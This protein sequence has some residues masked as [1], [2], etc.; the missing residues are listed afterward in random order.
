MLT[1]ASPGCVYF[2]QESKAREL[3]RQF[4]AEYPDRDIKVYGGDC[5]AEIPKALHDLREL[6]WAP[7]FAFIDPDGMEFEW[8]TLEALADHK[9]GY[10]PMSSPKPEYKVELWLLFPTQG[11][12]RTLALTQRSSP[13]G[14]SARH[15]ALWHRRLALSTISA[16]KAS[17]T[18][19]R[20]G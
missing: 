17:S 6:R 5:N 15:G 4:E 7:T 3:E 16:S 13:G 9:R 10:R 1:L 11:L 14:R 8:R 20:Q 12:V 2:E 18:R 19:R